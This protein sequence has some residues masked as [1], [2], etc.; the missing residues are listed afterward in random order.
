MEIIAGV[1]SGLVT[2]ALLALREEN[3][4]AHFI[5]SR[6]N[7]PSIDREP[8]RVGLGGDVKPTDRFSDDYKK[9]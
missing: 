6:A 7:T 8:K 2:S 9:A 4:I 1:M 3:L 5:E